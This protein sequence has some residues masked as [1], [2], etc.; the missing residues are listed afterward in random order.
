MVWYLAVKGKTACVIDLKFFG[1]LANGNANIL[2]TGEW[3]SD[4][5]FS[6]KT[7]PGMQ[8]GKI[9]RGENSSRNSR[10][11]HEQIK[12]LKRRKVSHSASTLQEIWGGKHR[13]LKLSLHSYIKLDNKHIVHR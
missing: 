2:L 10:S 5:A 3:Q 6:W 4:L 13:I 8:Y 1:R 7:L 11:F 12:Q 9:E